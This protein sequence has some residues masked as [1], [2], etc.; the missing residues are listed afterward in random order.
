[1]HLCLFKSA[2]HGTA[3]TFKKQINENVFLWKARKKGGSSILLDQTHLAE[4]F[5]DAIFKI[6]TVTE[7]NISLHSIMRLKIQQCFAAVSL[8]DILYL[9]CLKDLCT[10]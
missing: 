4:K 1:M 5:P 10:C 7:Q 6:W 9:Q 3:N 2:L 8:D